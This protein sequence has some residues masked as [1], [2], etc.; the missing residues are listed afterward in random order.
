MKS[1]LERVLI[2]H[3]NLCPYAEIRRRGSKDLLKVCVVL[4][5]G[6]SEGSGPPQ[7]YDVPYEEVL[8]GIPLTRPE[9]D[10]RPPAE[11]ELPWE[12]KKEQIVR[13]LSGNILPIHI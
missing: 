12:W 7:I 4:N 6:E 13:A 11:Y 1:V 9:S 10:S 8:E 3:V 5:G 2:P